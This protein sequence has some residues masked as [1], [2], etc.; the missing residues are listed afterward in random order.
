M[1]AHQIIPLS[2]KQRANLEV[3]SHFKINFC[4]TTKY[5]FADIFIYIFFFCR[6]VLFSRHTELQSTY[7][8]TIPPFELGVYFVGVLFDVKN[9]IKYIIIYQ[10][11][12][13]M[14]SMG[15]IQSRVFG[16]AYFELNQWR[17]HFHNIRKNETH[18]TRWRCK[19]GSRLLNPKIVWQNY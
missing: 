2:V 18:L 8:C 14:K 17:L 13:D 7:A 12:L 16:D 5:F 10:N 1:Y 15:S 9:N 3:Y 11:V 6:T 4:N 19:T